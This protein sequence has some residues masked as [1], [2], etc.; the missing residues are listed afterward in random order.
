MLTIEVDDR[1]FSAY[2]AQLQARVGDLS[3]VLA[4]IG[5][6]MENRISGRFET[7]SDPSGASWAPW[8]PA[9]LESYPKDGNRRLLDRYGDLMGSLNWHADSSSVTV[10]FG[11]PYAAYHEWGTKRMPRRGLMF[12]NPDAGTLA[13]A[14]ERAVIDVLTEWL[15]LA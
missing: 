15:D 2:W 1:A 5:Q 11:Q 8:A 7:E 3:P 14:D 10:G 13:P 4:A 12:Q 6:E 9:T